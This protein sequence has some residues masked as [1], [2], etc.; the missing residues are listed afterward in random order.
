MKLPLNQALA[1]YQSSIYRAAFYIC[2]NRHDAEDITQDTFLAYLKADDVFES[3]AHVKAWLLRVSVNKAKNLATSFWHRN[4]QNIDDYLN[5]L[6]YEEP[7]ESDLLRAVLKLPVKCR[8][9]VH[10][11]YYEDYSIKEIA[12]LLGIS[13]NTVKSQMNRGRML[14][15]KM[16][17]EEWEDD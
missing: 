4:S 10:L 8:T 7:E 2:K 15:K 17:K 12:D 13:E 14:L 6:T 9:I 1:K 11:Y 3:E 5:T 16:L